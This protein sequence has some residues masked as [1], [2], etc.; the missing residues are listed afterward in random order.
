MEFVIVN[1]ELYH[2]GV[3]G[4]KWGVRRSQDEL[5]RAAGRTRSGKKKRWSFKKAKKTSGAK[6]KSIDEM[7]DEERAAY[8][9]YVRKTA[10]PNLVYA[11]RQLFT[12]QELQSVY[13]RMNTEKNIKNLAPSK[14]NKGKKVVDGVVQTG[15][16]VAAVVGA[17]EKIY[18]SY[19]K[20]SKLAKKI[21]T[22]T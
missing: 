11:N 1:G 10:D 4:M 12:D 20:A 2:Y 9:E 22:H 16:T 5:D 15:V 21:G 7:T 19:G 13:L 18:S 17:A 3:K 8:K 6:T 14:V